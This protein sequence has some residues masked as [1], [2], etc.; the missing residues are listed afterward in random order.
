MKQIINLADDKTIRKRAED[1]VFPVYQWVRKDRTTLEDRWT[2]FWNMWK[3]FVDIRYYQ[4]Q[5]NIYLPI[6]RRNTE[7]GIQNIT[8][9]LF[10]TDDF[11]GVIGMPGTPATY[12]A[13]VKDMLVYQMLEEMRLP[14]EI[15]P[16]LRDM[17]ICGTNVGKLY[18][19]PF[20][21]C[22]K[23]NA[24]S[25]LEDFYLYPTTVSDI[26]EAM[27]TFERL[28]IDRFELERMADIGKY[29]NIDELP[30]EGSSESDT[31]R[32]EKSIDNTL[33]RNKQLATYDL[34][35]SWTEMELEGG[36]RE[37]VCISFDPTKEVILQITPSPLKYKTPSGEMMAFKPYVGMPLLK[38]PKSFYGHS[39]YE[40]SQRLQ[41]ALND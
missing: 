3:V 34:V 17:L 9:K 23:I 29:I 28:I 5:S 11:L 37:P 1:L 20:L 26:D 10:P 8:T 21:R 41:Y 24:L 18:F 22:P 27:I 19:D 7:E 25:L 2:Q 35:E 13:A 12:A 33:D 32:K 6:I 15:K 4:G 40:V 39:I 38:N 14:L 36:E 31:P 16:C 30:E